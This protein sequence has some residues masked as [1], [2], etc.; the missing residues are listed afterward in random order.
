MAETSKLRTVRQLWLRLSAASHYKRDRP[1]SEPQDT[2]PKDL[3]ERV[4]DI[5]K[6]CADFLNEFFDALGPK[7]YSRDLGTLYNRVKIGLSEK[8]FK[9]PGVRRDSNGLATGSGSDREIYIRPAPWSKSE[10]YQEFRWNAIATTVLNELLHHARDNGV[11]L[12]SALDKAALRLLNPAE[13]LAAKAQMK[14]KGYAAGTI[15]HRAVTGN[16]RP[17]NPYGPPPK[18]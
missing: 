11:F 7:V 6:N 1:E 14:Q 10:N 18:R 16:C 15:G 5:G 2:L 3:K 12:D 13:Q 9:S 8:P 17:T 4:E